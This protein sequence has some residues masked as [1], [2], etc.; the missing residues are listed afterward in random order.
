MFESSLGEEGFNSAVSWRWLLKRL[1][2]FH[3]SNACVTGL[4]HGIAVFARY[5]WM[6]NV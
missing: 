2:R 6:T 4:E 1:D 3:V 5:K